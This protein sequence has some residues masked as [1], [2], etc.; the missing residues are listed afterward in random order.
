MRPDRGIFSKLSL[1]VESQY[2]VG[3]TTLDY[4]MFVKA[5]DY[6]DMAA[7]PVVERNVG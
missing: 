2:T 4:R 3:F 1:N 6:L 5:C 7:F